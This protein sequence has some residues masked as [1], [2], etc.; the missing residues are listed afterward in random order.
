MMMILYVVK[1][2]LLMMSTILGVTVLVVVEFFSSLRLR[3]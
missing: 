1:Y 3:F 2:N